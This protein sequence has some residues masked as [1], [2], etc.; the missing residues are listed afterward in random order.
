M[1]ITEEER[2]LSVS[3]IVCNTA[4][5]RHRNAAMWLKLWTILLYAFGVSVVVFLVFAVLFLLREEWLPGVLTT[6]GT[7]V[8]G[9]SIKWV[10]DRRQEASEEEKSAYEEVEEHCED[11]TESDN[12]R[13]ELGLSR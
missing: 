2:E 10:F 13:A 3:D 8:E 9:V 11:T 5:L 7:I 6:L 1:T 4:R 12:L